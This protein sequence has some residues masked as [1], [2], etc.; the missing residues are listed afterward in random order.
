[1]GT[2]DDV[3]IKIG[4]FGRFQILVFFFFSASYLSSGWHA[5]S[6]VFLGANK[7][8][9]CHVTAL[10]NLTESQQRNIVEPITCPDDVKSATCRQCYGNV[11]NYSRYSFEDLTS[12]NRSKQLDGTI[13]SE[14][15]QA[16]EFSSEAYT[17]TLVDQFSLTCDR[18]WMIAM[19]QTIY[20]TGYLIGCLVF[21]SISDSFGRMK[22]Y[23]LALILEVFFAVVAIYVPWYPLYAVFRF[24]LGAT[25]GAVYTCAYVIIV[26]MMGPRHRT[27]V[28][29]FNQWGFDVGVL[30]CTAV[31]Y[32][33]K[34]HYS[35]Q[36]AF[37]VPPIIFLLGKFIIPE[38]PRWLV[39]KG[40]LDEAEQFLRKIAKFN[41]NPI[42]KTG[43]L[44]ASIDIEA[45]P[46][47]TSFVDLF[48]T[49]NLRKRSLLSFYVWFSN[50][51]I[52]YG[53]MFSASGF[54]FSI[55]VNL[56]SSGASAVISYF[57]VYVL[58]NKVGRRF[59]MMGS[60]V[61]SGVALFICIPLLY[62]DYLWPLLLVVSFLGKVANSAAF[63]G[64]Y[65]HSSEYYPTVIRSIGVGCASL[66]AR[67][68]GLL[69]PQIAR[70]STVWQPFPAIILGTIAI[71]AG[72]CNFFLPET[73]NKKLPETLEDGENF[74]TTAETQS[75]EAGVP[76]TEKEPA[77][78]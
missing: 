8:H 78:V 43:K 22:A 67:V 73:L 40:R 32:S 54:G 38:S 18:E 2:F 48:R 57:V 76:L 56:A 17:S 12:W 25:S 41:Q 13:T 24:M 27:A 66:F 71:T 29:I 59:S 55:F 58:F 20:M 46:V 50:S 10:R 37:A 51:A 34:D 6:M 3:L 72:L 42:T 64:G 28:G 14:K 45:K 77:L 36:W 44:V 16:W 4:E 15:C 75:D 74:G 5:A 53:L 21:G 23:L 35:M 52:Y 70:L 61:F 1:M 9:W 49:P 68:G 60:L 30:L 7:D 63:C 65:L 26:E 47:E 31:G 19:L 33:I 62:V 11:L 39:T 69:A